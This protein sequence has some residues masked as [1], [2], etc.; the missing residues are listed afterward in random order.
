MPEE[1]RPN[2]Y[3]YV[4]R[5]EAAAAPGDRIAKGARNIATRAFQGIPQREF[6]TGGNDHSPVMKSLREFVG[7]VHDLLDAVD[8]AVGEN[9]GGPLD[10][11]ARR[12]R[13]MLDNPVT[14]EPSDEG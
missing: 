2:P 12:V 1:K 10:T 7:P 14:L 8:E 6:L 3:P 11:A 5:A 9:G 13:D 4:T